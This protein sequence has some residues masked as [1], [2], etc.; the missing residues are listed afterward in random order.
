MASATSSNKR[1]TADPFEW[2]P[3]PH[4]ALPRL[5]LYYKSVRL[6]LWLIS[7]LPL[8]LVGNSR[9]PEPRP[10]LSLHQGSPKFQRELIDNPHTVSDP[11]LCPHAHLSL[12]FRLLLRMLRCW[13]PEYALLA[14]RQHRIFRGSIPSLALWLIVSFSIAPYRSLPPDTYSP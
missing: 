11:G 10:G 12:L 6:P 13:F 9:L 3:C 7:A 1:S 14:L 2:T 4:R 8:Q 5:R